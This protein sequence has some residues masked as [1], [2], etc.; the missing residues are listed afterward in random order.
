M[1]GK[2]NKEKLNN[3][4]KTRTN[5]KYDKCFAERI[6]FGNGFNYTNQGSENK[7]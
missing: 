1:Y 2:R 5:T 6:K 7:A 4:R 3:E